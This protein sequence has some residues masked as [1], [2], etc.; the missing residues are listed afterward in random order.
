[1]VQEHD[2]LV[3]D[4]IPDIIRAADKEPTVHA[5]ESDEYAERL[6]KKLDEEVTEYLESREVS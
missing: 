1:M 5:V 6:A 3:R 4:K 2:K